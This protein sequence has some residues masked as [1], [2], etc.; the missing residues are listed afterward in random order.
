M[1]DPPWVRRSRP[2]ITP[3]VCDP[4]G[5]VRPF[6]VVQTSQPSASGA[7]L[8]LWALGEADKPLEYLFDPAFVIAVDNTPSS[9]GL[10]LP[11]NG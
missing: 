10:A 3:V 7:E 8:L 4:K 6:S 11:V 2:T 1:N 5:M 9:I